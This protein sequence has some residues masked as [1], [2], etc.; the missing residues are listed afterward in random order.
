MNADRLIRIV[1]ADDHPIVREGLLLLLDSRPGFSVIGA[2][3]NGDA[4]VR[5]CVQ[6]RPD[7]LLL[8]L[9]MPGGDGLAVLKELSVWAPSVRT[10]VLSA[11][12]DRDSIEMARQLGAR[13]V[14]L[15]GADTA[16][17]FETIES[18]AQDERWVG[19]EAVGGNDGSLKRVTTQ[20]DSTT[21]KPK[22]FNLT[23]RELDIVDAIA[24]GESNK[25]IAQRLS[26]REDTVKHHL[27]SIF[28]KVGVFSRLELA[29]F[30][31]N[32]SLVRQDQPDFRPSP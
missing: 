28:D 8:D 25:E 7:V 10:I 19:G 6:L 18:V 23:R 26:V 11:F 16:V 31:F 27:S 14:L 21:R 15:K 22:P 2:A 5:L 24:V 1:I 9:V 13:R 4:A 30:A 12:L 29:V 20:M 3:G 17:L 32:H